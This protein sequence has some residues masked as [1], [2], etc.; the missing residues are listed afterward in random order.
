MYIY[1]AFYIH[2]CI[3]YLYY[4]L[5]NRTVQYIHLYMHGVLCKTQKRQT[6]VLKRSHVLSLLTNYKLSLSDTYGRHGHTHAQYILQKMYFKDS[7]FDVTEIASYKNIIL[8]YSQQ[9]QCRSYAPN[10]CCCWLSYGYVLCAATC[11]THARAQ[12]YIYVINLCIFNDIQCQYLI[13]FVIALAA[14]MRKLLRPL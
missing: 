6:L 10:N 12:K 9:S 4:L 1:V 7:H 2:I 8:A 11:C 5:Q 3:V 13:R 14:A